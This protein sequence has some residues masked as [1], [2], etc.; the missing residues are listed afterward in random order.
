MK[1][2]RIELLPE[3][4]LTILDTDR[5]RTNCLSATLL[6]PLRREEA[7]QNALL[8]DVLLRGCRLCPD[9]G[10]L[11]AWLDQRYGA[12]IQSTV[13]KKGEVQGIGFFLSW[14][15]E[16]FVPPGENLTGDLCALLGSFLLE[17]VL[18]NGAFRQDYV[19][20]EKVNLIN[21][22]AA[23]IN[24]KRVYA[25]TRMRQ[26]MFPEEAYGV[27]KNGEAAEVEAITPETLY[28]HYRDILAL[29]RIELVFAG[30]ADVDKLTS[31]LRVAL[32]ELPRG[33]TDPVGTDI[34]PMPREVRERSEV[35]DIKQGNLVMGFRTGVT[36][37]D[38]DYP[39]LLLLNAVYGGGI[40]SKLFRHV[41]EEMS[42][43]YYA[44]SGLDR[45]KGVMVVSSGVDFENYRRA[46][47]EILRQL[48][49][50]RAGEITEEE[51]DFARNALR[52]S[53]R[54]SGDSLGRMEDFYLSQEI[55]GFSYTPDDLREALETV[56]VQDLRRVAGSI[57]LDTIFFLK[58][59][60]E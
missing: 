47:D 36:S 12:D 9:M 29:S 34:G 59:A 20:G 45:F 23:Q 46:K 14:I 43:C 27:S 15:D 41:R 31:A 56:T 35:M 2:Q 16:K 49:L 32:K 25:A 30:R 58:G 11:S 57:R 24:D 4:Y 19:D 22:I 3:V 13:R 21:A 60:E 8:P 37:G 33:N 6:R 40:T 54:A 44:S 18:E 28:A 53:L 50:C 42:L 51:L 48:E 1:R 39:A 10:A 52:T 26:E 7:A 55:G 38:R 17:P 5:F